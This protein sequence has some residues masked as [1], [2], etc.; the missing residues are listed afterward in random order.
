VGE[1]E[2][3]SSA[4]APQFSSPTQFTVGIAGFVSFGL[5]LRVASLRGTG[6][7]GA[8]ALLAAEDWL[9]EKCNTCSS[10]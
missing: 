5:A 8:K 1:R 7:L 2:Q 10:S 4:A 9:G 6:T 3:T